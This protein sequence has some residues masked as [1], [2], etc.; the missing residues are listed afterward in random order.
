MR[1]YFTS[2]SAK[3][4]NM[5]LNISLFIERSENELDLA[6]VIYLVTSDEKL[7]KETFHLKKVQTFYS[8][9]IA[10]SYYSIFYA[11]KAYLLM[12]GIKTRPPS[13]HKETYIKFKELVAKGLVKKD[14]LKYYQEEYEKAE[15]LLKIFKTEKQKR[16]HF[17]YQKIA[18]ANKEPAHHSMKN[19]GLF[20][21]NIYHLCE[22]ST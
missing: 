12:K 13:E 11:A 18:Q 22:Q 8:G 3:V 20:F 10:H 21:K 6:G 7:Q 17:T 15:T 5:D 19:A 2:Y 9:V 16:G 1:E 14:L 4:L